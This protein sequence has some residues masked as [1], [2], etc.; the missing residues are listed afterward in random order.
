MNIV[1]VAPKPRLWAQ[2]KNWMFSG[3]PELVISPAEESERRLNLTIGDVR[4][5]VDVVDL[6][7]AIR[8]VQVVRRTGKV[9]PSLIPDTE[10]RIRMEVPR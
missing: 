4:A 3:A 2:L 6:I 7:E 8:Q 10:V 9:P 1:R 5:S